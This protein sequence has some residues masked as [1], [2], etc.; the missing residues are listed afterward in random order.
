VKVI[1]HLLSSRTYGVSQ[2]A[3]RRIQRKE[4][5]YL[6]NPN[7]NQLNRISVRLSRR[8]H[9]PSKC[10]TA[11]GEDLETVTIDGLIED[12]RR[13]LDSIDLCMLSAFSSRLRD[14]LKGTNADEY[15]GLRKA[16]YLIAQVLE[17]PVA[18]HARD[19]LPSWLAE[20]A[21]AASYFLKQFDL[22]PA[23]ILQRVIE[24]NRSE[25]STGLAECINWPEANYH[26]H[27]T[28]G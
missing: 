3:V 18:Q 26:E 22:V 8:R 2:C 14:K 1:A 27:T 19:P 9:R 24:R 16:V 23:L 17:S 4:I 13:Y 5:W 6:W 7:H 28:K 10:P 15:P 12:R 11:A 20:T 21:C 25:L